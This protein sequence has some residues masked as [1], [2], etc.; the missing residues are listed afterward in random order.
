MG[1]NNNKFYKE[2]FF[3][4]VLL[5]LIGSF[6]WSTTVLFISMKSVS[7]NENKRVEDNKVL[8]IDIA[9]GDKENQKVFLL[10]FKEIQAE[11]KKDSKE[12]NDKLNILITDVAVMKKEIQK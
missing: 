3:Y 8:S 5:L 6:G 2:K 7:A 9:E 1:E 10:A 12:I 4:I 11:Y